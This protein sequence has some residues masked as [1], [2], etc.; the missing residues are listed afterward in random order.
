[1]YDWVKDKDFLKRSYSDCAD[2][3]NQLVQEL[4]SYGI[5]AKMNV[6]GSKGRNMVTQN[7]NEGIDYDFN[8]LIDNADEYGDARTLKCNAQ[9][10]FNNVLSVNG[11]PD[12]ED[13]TSAL[14]T[15]EMVFKSGNKTPFHIDVCIVKY[16]QYGRL[17]RLIHEKW[18]NTW[19]DRYYWNTVPNSEALWEKEAELK[20]H[21]EYWQMVRQAYLGKKNMYLSRPY[22]N[23]HPSFICYVEAV[24]EVHNNLR[25]QRLL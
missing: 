21:A 9:K 18:G 4:K 12:C 7:A 6:V 16:D 2:I 1:M 8:L 10:A 13:S 3:V 25:A 24:N 15:K 20:P 22:D 23:S 19:T 5:D 17:Q 11:W 14:T